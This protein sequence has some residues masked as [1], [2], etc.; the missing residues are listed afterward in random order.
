MRK[1]KY[2]VIAIMAFVFSM[3]AASATTVSTYVSCPNKTTPGATVQCAVKAQVSG[4][5]I[6]SFSGTVSISGPASIASVNPASG[7]Q[8]NAGPSVSYYTG[9]SNITGNITIA[10]VSV[11]TTG[12]GSVV[13]KFTP[14]NQ[15]MDAATSKP[16]DAHNTGNGNITVQA[17]APTPTQTTKKVTTQAPVQ[18][19]AATTT[20][21]KA[22]V[23]LA[24]AE[25]KVEGF[26]MTEEN[27]IYYVT[28]NKDTE[29]VNI[30]ARAHDG[31][32]LTGE[33]GNRGLNDGKNTINY[34]LV[35]EANGRSQ[36]Y[37]L[38]ITK[39]VADKVDTSLKS[40]KVVNYDLKFSPNTLEYTVYVPMDTKEV[41]IM[42][43][44][45]NAEVSIK[46]S[47]LVTLVNGDN[48]AKVTVNYGEGNTTIYTIHIKKTMTQLFMWIGIAASI[49]TAIAVIV[50]FNLK[51]QGK[52]KEGIT[53]KLRNKAKTNRVA[54]AHDQNAGVTI[55]GSSVVG[56]GSQVV[57]PTQVETPAV[58]TTPEVKPEVAQSHEAP[59]PV[60]TVVTGQPAEV[61]VVTKTV[62]PTTV[63][64]VNTAPQATVVN[65][66]QASDRI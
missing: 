21:T 45:N 46:G 4:G 60:K 57:A 13:V 17:P 19:T 28:V 34:T 29:S 2:F 55:G 24:F 11:K 62:V 58:A 44:A 59:Q 30:I 31:V 25:L 10:N 12:A 50:Y 41:Y 15:I 18:T 65:T 26:E 16:I 38:I 35:D 54:K 42:A 66:S 37:Q 49:I 56:F 51:D 61:K 23:S 63:Q 3:G 53:D 39:P 6:E 40:L 52:I 7:W 8:G 14:G 32:K 27:G 9:N 47:G 64:T 22:L 33:T 48:V 5:S 36:N 20:T 1:I 43:E